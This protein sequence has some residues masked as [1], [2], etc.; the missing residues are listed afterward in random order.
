MAN[1]EKTYEELV[2]KRNRFA[3]EL[4][5][6]GPLMRAFRFDMHYRML[7]AR[8]MVER[9][10]LEEKD[11]A[12]FLTRVEPDRW[13]FEDE[14]SSLA[15]FRLYVGDVKVRQQYYDALESLLQ[16][17]AKMIPQQREFQV[18]YPQHPLSMAF[19]FLTTGQARMI[20]SMVKRGNKTLTDLELRILQFLDTVDLSTSVTLAA[21]GRD[22]AKRREAVLRTFQIMQELRFEKPFHFVVD[23][24]LADPRDESG[25]VV[26][27]A[28]PLS[29]AAVEREREKHPDEV[30]LKSPGKILQENLNP[31]TFQGLVLLLNEGYFLRYDQP[32]TDVVHLFTQSELGSVFPDTAPILIVTLFADLLNILP[33]GYD[34][35]THRK[36]LGQ[37]AFE[38]VF[39][40]LEEPLRW[41]GR[42]WRQ[43]ELITPWYRVP[44]SIGATND[45]N[46]NVDNLVT[47]VFSR[48]ITYSST[49]RTFS[50]PYPTMVSFDV[51]NHSSQRVQVPLSSRENFLAQSLLRGFAK[52]SIVM[53]SFFR[54][55]GDFVLQRPGVP[56]AYQEV[57]L[58]TSQNESRFTVLWSD[59]VGSQPIFLPSKL[60]WNRFWLTNIHYFPFS[61]IMAYNESQGRYVFHTAEEYTSARQ[62]SNGNVELEIAPHYAVHVMA[63]MIHQIGDVVRE[64]MKTVVDLTKQPRPPAGKQLDDLIDEIIT[65]RQGIREAKRIVANTAEHHTRSRGS[66]LAPTLLRTRFERSITQE[67]REAYREAKSAFPLAVERYRKFNDLIRRAPQRIAE[68]ERELSQFSPF[69]DNSTIAALRQELQEVKTLVSSNHET[70]EDIHNEIADSMTAY[71]EFKRMEDYEIVRNYWKTIDDGT[72]PTFFLAELE[73][74][75]GG[76]AEYHGEFVAVP[77]QSD[78]ENG[79]LALVPAEGSVLP[80]DK[81]TLVSMQLFMSGQNLANHMHTDLV[82]KFLLAKQ[83]LENPTTPPEVRERVEQS[84]FVVNKLSQGTGLAFESLQHA[85]AEVAES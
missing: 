27:V 13:S 68:I 52:Q 62:W 82:H 69:Q 57:N 6:E 84:I 36:V 15:S 72:R 63:E 58:R 33:P 16:G 32:E 75:R 83:T 80:L 19:F 74:L 37:A 85:R 46:L 35:V 28:V 9:G 21:L 55:Q 42:V 1:T 53:S 45:P 78:W 65:H 10:E 39:P 3:K 64:W 18:M 67:V 54:I 34:Q 2:T 47:L 20:L 38:V 76:I 5:L 7:K 22:P 4:I 77:Q 43:P 49:V 11:V 50:I 61:E 14:D 56:T 66:V 44:S 48:D 29:E 8:E 23:E 51:R 70:L 17:A 40:A 24:P 31:S 81:I 26:G 41:R 59:D 60:G 79:I 12:Q 73:E 71:A 25:Y 30:I